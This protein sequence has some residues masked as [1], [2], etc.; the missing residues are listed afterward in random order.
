MTETPKIDAAI[1]ALRSAAAALD[2]VPAVATLES[3]KAAQAKMFDA[4][5]AMKEA[6]KTE[7]Y[8]SQASKAMDEAAEAMENA[9]ARMFIGLMGDADATRGLT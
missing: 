7:R 6:T 8:S 9:L 4:I 1:E 5:A 3:F 2:E